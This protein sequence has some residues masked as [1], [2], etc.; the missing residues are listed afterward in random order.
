MGRAG[1]RVGLSV[2]NM[3]YFAQNHR[4]YFEENA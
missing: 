4:F 1:E 3:T 2:P